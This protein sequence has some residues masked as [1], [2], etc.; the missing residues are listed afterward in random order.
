MKYWRM[1]MALSAAVVGF[2][3]CKAPEPEVIPEVAHVF[4]IEALEQPV[5]FNTAADANAVCDNNLKHVERLRSEITAV[6]GKHDRENT[7]ERL[8]E[9]DIAFERI[10]GISEL[11]ANTHP[12]ESVRTAAENCTTKAS[13]VMTDIQMDPDLYA[14]VHDVDTAKL[15]ERAKRFVDKTLLAYR[16]SGVDK[17]KDTRDKLA[18]LDAAI[19]QSGQEFDKNIRD[20][21]K[22]IQFTADQLDGLPEDFMASHTPDENGMITV[23][24]DYTDYF[25]VL[26]YANKEETRAALA[27]LFQSR[28]YPANEAVFKNLLQERY[29]FAKLTGFDNWAAY[30]SY[31][32]MAKN[33]ETISNFI[34]EIARIT[35]PRAK[36]EIEELMALKKADNPD[37]DGFYPW[38]RFYYT[39]KLK[40]Q[41]Y[42]F[43][44]QSVRQYFPYERVKRGILSVASTLYGVTFQQSELPVWHDKVEAYDVYQG[45]QLVARFYLDMHPREGKYG[46]AASFGMYSGIDGLQIPAATLVCN[47][48]EPTPSNPA[49]MEHNDVQTFFHEFGH[50]LHQLLAAHHHWAKQSGISCEWDFVEA[51]SQLFED[52]AWDYDVLKMFAVNDKGEVIPKELVDRMKKSDSVGKGV[53]NMRQISYAALSYI[54]HSQDPANIDL[55]KVQSETFA[56]YS[57]F[58]AYDN[59]YTF[60]SF[61]HLNGYSSMYYTYMWSLAIAKDLSIPFHNAGLMNVD[62]AHKYRDTILSVGGAQDAND[63]VSNFLGRPY[64]LDAFKKWLSE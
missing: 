56:K 52:W 64:N 24:T 9:M 32:K 48:P 12:D 34:A 5:I 31:D 28:A 17:D 33:T 41:K 23:S 13:K 63:M 51:P 49:L 18:K 21:R 45:D 26:N 47:F 4:S 20:D 58:K 16:L 35:E 6:T 39:E 7:L 11:M 2:S 22:T 57:P 27:K 44:A 1:I 37:A 43:D 53:M 25:P 55:L 3:G 40:K 19:V 8:N 54:Y 62:T 61:G 29:E 14:A 10:M 46:H 36:A 15:D 42:D 59:D 30:N 50:L 60:A 38:D